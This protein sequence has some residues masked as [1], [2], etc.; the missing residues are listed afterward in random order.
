MVSP[1]QRSGSP[2]VP[3]QLRTARDA[4]ALSRAEVAAR[5]DLDP[6]ELAG[7]EDGSS[8]PPVEVL[9]DLA[10]LYGR[11]TDYFV[12]QTPPP[13]RGVRFRLA[14]SRQLRDL[15][16]E[17]RQVLVGFEEYCRAARELEGLIGRYRDV[18]ITKVAQALDAEALATQERV[19][20]GLD[21]KPIK[22]LRTLLNEQGVQTFEL[23]IPGDL[24]AGLSWWP[25]EYGPCVLINARDV[26]GRRAFTLAHEYAHLLR[27]DPPTLCDLT[28]QALQNRDERFPEEFAASLLMPAPAV[29]HDFRTRGLRPDELTDKQL[30]SLARRY[31]VSL[32]AMGI[33]LEELGLITAGTTDSLVAAWKARGIPPRRPKSP[34]WRRRLGES[35]VSMS[36]QAYEQG[37][38]SAAKLARYLGL[39]IRKAISFA[40]AEAAS[41]QARSG[42]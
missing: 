41:R 36:L 24:F 30:A 5:V 11:S 29:T 42:D 21:E 9:W 34:S 4:L 15:P 10:D 6:K 38:V 16:L 40:E 20:M 33:R 32:Q 25:D 17:V 18:H 23:P 12:R 31:G 22:D 28:R 27:A 26:A 19:R 1:A 3:Q 37:R 14:Q 7:W 8:E 2:L 39:D 35:Y 13:L